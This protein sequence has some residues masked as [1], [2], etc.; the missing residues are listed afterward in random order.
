MLRGKGLQEDDFIMFFTKNGV[1]KRMS[2][3]ELRN[4]RKNGIR[5]LDI[6]EG[7]ELVQ[8]RSRRTAARS[9]SS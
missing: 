4:V 6:R 8:R 1:T 2:Q 9:C 7:D 5:A 3:G